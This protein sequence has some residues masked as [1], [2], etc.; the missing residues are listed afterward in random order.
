MVRNPRRVCGEVLLQ[1]VEALCLLHVL[2]LGPSLLALGCFPGGQNPL[3]PAESAHSPPVYAVAVYLQGRYLRSAARQF[4]ARSGF[5]G[6][7]A[8]EKSVGFLKVARGKVQGIVWPGLSVVAE[9]DR[10]QAVNPDR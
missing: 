2:V 1:F 5:H 6:G 10:P 9:S 8:A 4:P 3:L 7:D